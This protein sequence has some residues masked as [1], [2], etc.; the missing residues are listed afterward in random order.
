MEVISWVRAHVGQN[1]KLYMFKH[2]WALIHG[3]LRYIMH[4]IIIATSLA[5]ESKTR[6][7]TAH[8]CDHYSS[9]MSAVTACTE[10][11]FRK[12]CKKLICQCNMISDEPIA[13]ILLWLTTLTLRVNHCYLFCPSK[14]ERGRRQ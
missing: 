14:A 3:K 5:R 12:P 10:I 11:L 7:H 13:I 1:H 4:N 6:M 8:Y 2:S 9:A